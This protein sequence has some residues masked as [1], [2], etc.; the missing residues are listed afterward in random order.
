MFRIE[1]WNEGVHVFKMFVRGKDIP[2][3]T[4]IVVAKGT[5][6]GEKHEW[7]C[8]CSEEQIEK[9]I[10]ECRMTDF[11][12]VKAMTLQQY[13]AEMHGFCVFGGNK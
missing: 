10:E 13:I 6:D 11:W 4:H 12:Y 9:A 3:I 2:P 7:H 1:P 8:P 5:E